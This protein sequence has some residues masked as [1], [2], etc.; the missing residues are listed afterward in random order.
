[1]DKVMIVMTNTKQAIRMTD[2]KGTLRYLQHLIHDKP[3]W[4]LRLQAYSCAQQHA[5][6][7][8]MPH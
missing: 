6:P 8:L 3:A 2:A 5:M 4:Q 7:A 1:M